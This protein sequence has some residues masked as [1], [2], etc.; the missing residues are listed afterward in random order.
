MKQIIVIFILFSLAVS[1]SAQNIWLNELHYDNYSTDVGEFLEIVLENAGSYTLN[2]FT[3]TLYNGNAGA[4]YDSKTL[5]QFTTGITSDTFTLYYYEFPENGIQNGAP[6]GIAIDYQGT[7]IPGQFLSYEGTFEAGDGPAVGVM[8]TDIGVEEGGD[9]QIG[10]SL[11]LAGDGSNYADFFWQPPAAETPGNLNNGQTIGGAPQPTIIVSSP[12]GG[13]QWE[14]GSTHDINWISINFTDNV[15]I[16]LEQV[17]ERTREILVASTENDGSWEWNIPIDQ[18]ISDWYVIIISDAIDGDPMDQ[19]DDPFSIIEPIPITSYTIYEIQYSTTGP[20]PHVGEL[21]ETSGVVTAIFDLY[22]FI[23]DGDG[24]WN[25]IVIY[26]MQTV[27]IGDEIVISGL[28]DEYFDKTEITDIINMTILGS[29]D[30]PAPVII[31]TSDLASSEDYEGVLVQV[32]NVTVTNEDLGY[33]EW[34]IDDGS[35]PCVVGDLGDYTYVPVLNDFIYS[36]TGVSDYTY[37]AFKLEPRDDVDILMLP[38]PDPASNPNPENGAINVSI[39]ADLNWINGANTN[40]ID[41]YF[42]NFNP[43]PL[44]LE[45]NTPIETYDPG[46][47][48]YEETYYWKVVCKNDVGSSTAEL[49]NFITEIEIIPPEPAANPNPEDGAINVSINTDLSWTNGNNTELIDFY[50]GNVDPPPLILE[51]NTPIETYDPGTLDYEET[52]YW[53]VV[54]KNVAG[55]STADIWDFTTEIENIPPPDPATNP[56]PENGAIDVSVEVDLNWTNGTNTNLI[57]LYFGNV[58]PPPLV[59]E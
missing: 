49:W 38:P 31:S 57:D 53:K 33:G 26:P 11:Q 50:F 12:N 3:I 46:T 2:D 41:L 34:E 27:A 19:S 21:V 58:D 39:E 40:L 14:Q 23:Q 4:I 51:N 20:S 1:L 32:Q 35:G 25:G 54:C 29:A 48:D 55:S 7:L 47:L 17:Y 18:L 59:L 13:E 9:T 5:D 8:S 6:D 36:I 56:D 45:N 42:G 44:I 22:F 30:L 24:A 10:E 52:Y 43:P 28:V 37:E 15:K 16:E